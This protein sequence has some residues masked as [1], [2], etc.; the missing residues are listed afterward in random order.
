MARRPDDWLSLLQRFWFPVGVVALILL[1]IPGLILF[2]LNVF[3]GEEN[4]NEWLLGNIQLTYHIPFPWWLSLFL[5][6]IPVAIIL[7]YFLKLKRKPLSVPSTFLWKKSIE[8]LHVNALFQWLRQNL[9]LLLQL[10]A[11]LGMIYAIMD[12]KLHGRTQEA[13]YY[14]VLVD[15]SASMG[16]TD[17]A[18]TRLEWA[19]Q[20]ALKEIDA[21]S[22]S[23]VGM[24][25][26]FNS[27][28]EIVQSYTNNRG[29]LRQAVQSIEQTQRPTR[30]EEALSLADSLA[31]P[32]RSA[33]DNSVKPADVTPGKERTYVSAEGVATAVHIYSDGRFP[34]LP[35]FPLGNISPQYHLAGKPGPENTNNVAVVTFN[36]VRDD[37][38]AS[39]MQ[40]FVRVANFRPQPVQAELELEV[41]VNGQVK[42]IQKKPLNLQARQVSKMQEQGKEESTVRDVPG[43]AAVVFELSDVN[44]RDITTL[45]AKLV[46]V[47]DD[48]AA[49][50]EAWLVVGVVRKARILL[51]GEANDILNAFFDDSATL[52]VATLTKMK[53]A[54][55]SGGVYRKAAQNGEFDLVIFDRCGPATEEDMPRSNTFFIGY[56]PPPWKPADM[57]KVTNPQIKGWMHKHPVLRYLVAL[58][59]IGIAEAFKLKELPTR[60]PRLMEIDQNV[61]VLF[62]LN[63]QLYSDLVMTFPI[64]NAKS[65]WNTN[66]PLLPSFPLFLRNVIYTYG[67]ISDG[68]SEE[69]LQA[70]QVKTLRP[71]AAVSD[72]EVTD[73]TGSAQRIERGSR[74][75]FSY[76][77]TDRLGLYRV[78]WGDRKW[79]RSFAVNLLD[80]DESAI[81]PRSSV[82]IGAK[83][84]LA[85]QET[86]QPRDLWKWLIVAALGMLLLEWYVYNRRIFV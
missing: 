74:T 38:D 57:E 85:G 11:V 25:I 69:A 65:E 80:V 55:L 12:F 68:A 40:A 17:V 10:L 62:T 5:L 37:Q 54:D 53:P 86:R 6:M 73:P 64:I 21:A 47:K 71:D 58:Q 63:R 39:K 75:E 45:H 7:L 81:E 15:N 48:L 46:G 20:E 61:T 79:Q 26:K 35:D 18:P 1:A 34:D 4:L 29:V 2:G 84:I 49:D 3:G 13:R 14:I 66:W 43:E 67:N 32:T 31:N 59:E 78:G 30:I 51:V 27:S 9:L 33:D 72:I 77:Q 28:A 50:D 60:T 52:D 83:E 42:G 41:M 44:D 82:Q 23:D 36:A 56:P 70:G 76:G 16:A 22:D 24:V 8:D 19:K